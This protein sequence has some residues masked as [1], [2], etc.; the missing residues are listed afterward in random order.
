VGDQ[1]GVYTDKVVQRFMNREQQKYGSKV[2]W[3]DQSKL[4]E[5]KFVF[6]SLQFSH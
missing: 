2:Y 1:R 4:R 6:H 3:W 5:A